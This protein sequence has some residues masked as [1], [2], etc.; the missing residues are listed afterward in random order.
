M[1]IGRIGKDTYMKNVSYRID[2][3]SLTLNPKYNLELEMKNAGY[4]LRDPEE[5]EAIRS[6]RGY[7]K[8]NA[9]M[10]DIENPGHE[11]PFVFTVQT[12]YEKEKPNSGF[13]ATSGAQ[14]DCFDYRNMMR[15]LKDILKATR[16]DI[17]CDIE[18]ETREELIQA[19]NELCRLVGFD[20]KSEDPFRQN[21]ENDILPG[22]KKGARH[23]RTASLTASNGLT[24]Y[25]GGRES[26]FMMRVYDKSA[27]VLA[28]TGVEIEP[29]LRLEIEAKQE[30]ADGVVKALIE[31][32][33][34]NSEITKRLWHEVSEDHISFT[35]GTLAEVMSIPEANEIEID[36]TKREGE[37]LGFQKWVEQQVAPAFHR[38]NDGM[39]DEDK[40]LKLAQYFKIKTTSE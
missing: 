11:K 28:K 34:A 2:A 5:N 39:S 24:L 13:F 36:Y 31:S 25:I 35:E 7:N 37:E 1:I 6:A 32:D 3:L 14:L 22:K 4:G 17:A 10:L 26:K 8:M 15:E 21:P 9:K 40:L 20:A 33:L 38:I 18:Y 16:V 19:Q 27:E 29:T 30:V 12:R 23:I